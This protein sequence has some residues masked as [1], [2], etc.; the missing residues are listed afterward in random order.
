MSSLQVVVIIAVVGVIEVV[1]VLVR[2]SVALPQ[3][4]LEGGR[5]LELPAPRLRRINCAVM[6][7]KR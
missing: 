2:I 3:V 7:G 1:V 6:S 5:E 4:V